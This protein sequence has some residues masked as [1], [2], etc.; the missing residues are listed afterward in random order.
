MP[1]QLNQENAGKILAVRVGGKLAKEDYELFLPELERLLKQHGKRRLLFEVTGFHVWDLGAL[2][3]EIKFDRKH[4][5]EI[6]RLAMVG[7]TKWQ[8]GV[9]TFCTPFKSATI[10]YFDRVDAAEARAWLE[11]PR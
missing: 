5:S 6:E 10:R 1:I 9:A 4:F 11:K 8:H 7:E 2:W 3:E